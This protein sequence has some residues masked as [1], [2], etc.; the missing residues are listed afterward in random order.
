M[1]ETKKENK[2][3][4]VFLLGDIKS[5][6]KKILQHYIQNNSQYK[7]E[8]EETNSEN[9]EKENQGELTQSFEIHGETIKMKILEDPQTEQIFSSETEISSQPNGIL[10]FYNVN[11]KESFDKLKQIISKIIEMNKEEMPIVIVGNTS[12]SDQ[13]GRNVSYEEAKNFADNYGLKYHETSI[14]SNFINMTDVFKDLGEQ[15]LYQDILETKAKKDPDKFK[16]IKSPEKENDNENTKSKTRSKSKGEL[17]SRKEKKTMVQKKREDEIREKRLKREKEMQMWYKKKEREGIELRKKKAIEDKIKLKEKIKED[18]LIQKQREKEVK[19]E[20]LNQ[21][22]EKY[23]KFK[24]EKEEGEKKST[25]EKE[26]NKQLLEKKRKSEKENMKKLLLENELNDKEYLKKQRSKIHSPQSNPRS[27]Q[28]KNLE[29]NLD[30]SINKTITDFKNNEKE[31]LNGSQVLKKNKTLANLF[32]SKKG[33]KI[34]SKKDKDKDKD[35]ESSTIKNTKSK[36]IRKTKNNKAKTDNDN[37]DKLMEKEMKEK[38]EKEKKEQEEKIL[39]EKM[40]LKNELKEKY[41]NNS[42]IYRCLNCYNI[43]II[44]INEFNH[45]IETYCNSC[46]C[47]NSSNYIISSYKNFEDKSLNHPINNDISCTSCNKNMDELLNENI[48]LNFCNI[49]NEIICSKDELTHKNERHINNNELKDKYKNLLTNKK[50]EDKNKTYKSKN[51]SEIKNNLTT[52]SKSHITSSKKN[53]TSKGKQENDENRNNNTKKNSTYTGNKNANKKTTVK[54]KNTI[55]NNNDEK[56]EKINENIS[57]PKEEKLPFY[58][59]DSCCIEHGEINNSYCHDCF[60]NICTKCEEKEHKNHN[61]ECLDKILI[62]DEKLLSIKQSVE[63][64]IND[65]NNI[66]E[67]FN[68]LIEKIKE[69]FLYFYSLK[70]KEIEIKQKIIQ[71]YEIIKY[72]YNCIQNIYKISSQSINSEKKTIISNL[73][74]LNIEN[75]NDLL[76]KLK[77]IFNYLYAS[78]QSTNLF[79]YYNNSKFVSLNNQEE[80]TNLIKL[81][82]NDISVSFFNGC[83]SIYD[84][85]HFNPKLTC[86]VFEKNKGINTLIQLK[87]GDLACTGYEKI[88]IVNIDL[89]DKMYNIIKELNIGDC[90]INLME[91]LRNNYLITYDCNNDLKLWNNY[92]IIYKDNLPGIDNLQIINENSFITSSIKDQKLYLYN[93]LNNEN[94][95][96]K[97][98]CCSLDNIS[99]MKGKNSIVKLNNNYIVVIYDE[100][101]MILDDD[102]NGDDDEFEECKNNEENYINDNHNGICLIEIDSKNRLKIVQKIKNEKVINNIIKYIEDSILILNDFG[103]IEFWSFDK[104]N[105]KMV[106]MNKFNAM[107]NI[108]C[109]RIRSL[110]F[111]EEDKKIII[112]NYKNLIYLSHK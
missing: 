3:Y 29:T 77:L 2:L 43:P 60:K 61:I 62:D 90:S 98:T 41:L 50:K 30:Q 89:N 40:K 21:N 107:D 18:K 7:N 9:P 110:L 11:D 34:G 103:D 35:K 44:N 1:E 87:N 15:V 79:N 99:V 74:K 54:K 46:N 13:N 70:Q 32:S 31:Y 67:Y 73:E 5:E 17:S 65:L 105:R 47:K 39:E 36:S 57:K 23:E 108:Y 111:I 92:K 12:E 19:E 76:S 80:I 102:T 63:E 27:R 37:S 8:S 24:K 112:Q 96:V 59:I 94:N 52:P 42:N 45:Q 104:V 64:D 20:Y 58:L 38:Q 56:I 10:L 97:I 51:S 83:V 25:L 84:T 14:E 85:E 33:N 93:I 101:K 22:K 81:D 75:N 26:K 95:S 68:Q 16:E 86:K 91:E 78:S 49:C 71:D 82:N 6:K 53:P 4:N 109:K 88:K 72:N 48:S 28:N 66:N 55:N 106:I 69:Q 100:N